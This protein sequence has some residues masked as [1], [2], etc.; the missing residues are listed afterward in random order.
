MSKS[1][2]LAPNAWL[3]WDLVSRLL[4]QTSKLGRVVEIGVGQGGFAARLAERALRYTGF[5]PDETSWQ[6]ASSRLRRLPNAV[7]R[8]TAVPEAQEPDADLLCAF[9]V[10]EH[11]ED[12]L[13]ALRC[14]R[15]WVVPGGLLMV[16]VPARPSAFGPWDR[17]VG[18][19]RR[20]TPGMLEASLREAGFDNVS[21]LGYGF[22]LGL[23]LDFVRNHVLA[24]QSSEDP[25]N[26]TSRSGRIYQPQ[27]WMSVVLG[28]VMWPFRLLQRPWSRS[29]LNTGLVGIGRVPN[30][31]E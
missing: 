27:N 3:R 2:P 21:V 23:L 19:L 1:S 20:Y 30:E 22:P 9:E 31:V 24:P 29:T 13:A 14:W 6:I 26:D 17:A 15:E 12:D 25:L 5:E 18:H 11:L 16:S 10:L 8:Q 7:V 4:P 28:V